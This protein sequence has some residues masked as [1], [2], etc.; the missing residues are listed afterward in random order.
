MRDIH[1]QIVKRIEAGRPFGVVVVLS[2][3]GSTPRE[4][5]VKAIVDGAGRI[6][7]TI[8]GGIVEAEAQR[9][10]IEACRTG[11]AA[12]V[13]VPLA[14]DVVP[15]C[16]PVCGGE[17]RVLVD[18]TA[19]KDAQAYSAAAL[20]VSER[21]QGLLLTAVRAG[22]AVRTEVTWHP[23][24][25]A[26]SEHWS[27][28]LVDLATAQGCL[29]DGLTRLVAG[30][31]LDVLVEPVLPPPRLVIAGGG[32]V[33]RALAAQAV[34]V[35]FEVTVIDDRPEFADPSGL[36]DGV[37]TQCGDIAAALAESPAD[38]DTYV[39]IVTRGHGHD[40]EA[41]QA[42]LHRPF[43]YVGMIGSRRK[44]ALIRESFLASGLATAEELDAVHAPI[45]LDIGA[46]TVPEIAASIVAELIAVR[47]RGGAHR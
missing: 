10:A 45:G 18:P 44:V 37:H 42:C 5:G 27:E 43:A 39:V 29:A 2:A 34:L 41:L 21:R 31:G 8:G 36:P 3:E 7:G 38:V 46:E 32:H 35:G 14:G 20:A 15:G 16:E 26:T 9:A 17:M 33:G 25:E 22:E 19:A 13:R 6:A 40:A 12:I 11:R 30:E 23:E 4:A 1:S 28:P 24:E 47:R